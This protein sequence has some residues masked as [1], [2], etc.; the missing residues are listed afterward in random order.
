MELPNYR[1]PSAKS[2][3][4]L[5]WEKAKHFIEKAC[6]II[7]IGSVII[8]FLS[9]FT[10]TLYPIMENPS[11]TSADSILGK[12]GSILAVLFAPLGFGD[13]RAV[14][15]LISGFTAKEAVVATLELLSPEGI[16]AIFTT[17]AASFSFL[18]FTLI[19]TP[20]VAAVAAI[21]N[22]LKSGWATVGVVFMQCSVAWIVS[23]IVYRAALLLPSLKFWDYLIAALIVAI[24]S[25]ALIVLKKKKKSGKP[26]CCGGCIGGNCE[27]CKEKMNV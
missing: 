9:N 24:I 18:V 14:T 23:F 8:W 12:L 22:E 4:L 6:T 11:L 7:M 2:V 21:K 17:T 26:I 16:S 10:P 1:L 27:N 20:C 13:W 15:A 3:L 19:Y 25:A 5:M